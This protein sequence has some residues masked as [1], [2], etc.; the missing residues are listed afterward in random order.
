MTL[1]AFLGPC[2]LLAVGCGPA[3]DEPEEASSSTGAPGESGGSTPAA[4]V[5]ATS[6]EVPGDDTTSDAPT[7]STGEVDPD[8]EWLG[9]IGTWECAG[10][11]DPLYLDIED[12]AFDPPA[13]QGRACSATLDKVHPLEGDNCGEL[14]IHGGGT[15]PVY[16]LFVLPYPDFPEV[17]PVEMELLGG[18]DPRAD[19][20]SGLLW[21]ST[22][23]EG[24]PVECERAE[25]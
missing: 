24:I 14:M 22:L 2:L 13:V 7:G 10:F 15:A 21:V 19:V 1:R 16:V 5:T 8:E 6:D 25:V 18:Y 23:G 20:V 4:D 12:F 17:G 9:V 3:L 11:D